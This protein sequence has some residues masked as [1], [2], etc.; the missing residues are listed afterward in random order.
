[1][2]LPAFHGLQSLV[3]PPFTSSGAPVFPDG[4]TITLVLTCTAKGKSA[5]A[6]IA[7]PIARRP[8]CSSAASC[9]TVSPAAG[10]ADTAFTA[11]AAGFVANGALTYDFGE[12]LAGGRS[13]YHVRGRADP[14]YIFARLVLA[15][16]THTLFV[17]AKGEWRAGE[18]LAAA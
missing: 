3:I 8:S 10:P 7:V 15:P 17:C 6:S 13:E 14:Q 12:R 16:G 18:G 2:P 1:M 11:T 4:A 9:L 5:S